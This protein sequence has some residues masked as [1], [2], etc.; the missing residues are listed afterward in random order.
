M[1]LIRVFGCVFLLVCFFT[2]FLIYY[3][4][5]PSVQNS[6]GGG[7]LINKSINSFNDKTKCKTFAQGRNNK[8][9][10]Q[11]LHFCILSDF[12]VAINWYNYNESVTY[13]THGDVTFLDNLVPLAAVWDGPISMA[14]YTP[15]SDFQTAVQSIN[16]LRKCHNSIRFKVTFHLVLDERHV[17]SVDSVD[18]EEKEL[19]DCLQ[20]PPSL[21]LPQ[22]KTFR[23]VT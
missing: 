5:P 21:N 3:L 1:Q 18:K 16:Y 14:I 9:S 12:V 10:S 15:G 23:Q 8:Q 7:F 20:R 19:I 4:S 2:I 13:T 11:R 17:P 22:N 6:K